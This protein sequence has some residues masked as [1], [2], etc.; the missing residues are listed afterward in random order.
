MAKDIITAEEIR[1]FTEDE[2]A[3][4]RTVESF[5]LH[6]GFKLF[7]AIY[8]TERAEILQKEDYKSLEDFKADRKALKIVQTMLDELESYKDKAES[9]FDRL[10]KLE[11]AE[12]QTPSLLSID[13]EGTEE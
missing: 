11:K 4:G 13:G 8:L 2:V 3:L 7:M 10:T 12:S 9:A 1:K 6:N 5:L